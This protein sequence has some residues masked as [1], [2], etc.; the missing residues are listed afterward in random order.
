MQDWK[1]IKQGSAQSKHGQAQGDGGT[2]L[3]S[4]ASVMHRNMRIKKEYLT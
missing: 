4:D 2:S 3:V 1:P